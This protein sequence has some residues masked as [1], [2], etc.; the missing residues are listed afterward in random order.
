MRGFSENSLQAYFTTILQTEYRHI[1]SPN[2]YIHTILDYSHFKNKEEVEK[3]TISRNLT[4]LGLGIGLQTKS[5]IFKIAFANGNIKKQKF[6]IYNTI[7]HIS[8]NV[9]F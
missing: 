5:G 3:K 7:I 1:I 8:Y 2:L 4:G 9:K 6:E